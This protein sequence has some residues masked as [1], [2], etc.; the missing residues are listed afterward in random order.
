M[1]HEAAHK[2]VRL[3]SPALRGEIQGFIKPIA[4]LRTQAAEPAQIGY[5]GTPVLLQC[6]ERGIGRDHRITIH[7]VL[8]GKGLHAVGFIRIVVR[9][10]PCGESALGHAP[11]PAEYTFFLSMKTEFLAFPQKRAFWR[12]HKQRRHQ[13]FE[14]GARPGSHAAHAVGVRQRAAQPPPVPPRRFPAG[15]SQVA[16]DPSFAFQQVIPAFRGLVILGIPADPQEFLI[17]IV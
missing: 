16:G 17:F 1:G 7:P 2:L 11:Y 4:T 5:G 14:H 10:V 12:G 13:V 15:Y 3:A 6:Q 8:Q 9:C